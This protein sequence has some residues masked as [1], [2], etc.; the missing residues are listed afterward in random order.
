MGKGANLS[1]ERTGR[2]R[3][4]RPGAILLLTFG[5]LIVFAQPA[6]A[7]S[8][9]S[10]RDL[11]QSVGLSYAYHRSVGGS[12]TET[13]H[14]FTE[15]YGIGFSYSLLSPLLLKGNA[16]LDLEWL[17]RSD[18]TD[19]KTRSNSDFRLRY[20]I[21]GQLLSRMPYPVSIAATSGRES[22]AQS[23]APSYDVV[24]DD[25]RVRLGVLND[26]VPASV[27]FDRQSQD[28]SGLNQNFRQT[29]NS[30]SIAATPLLGKIATLSLGVTSSESTSTSLDSNVTSNFASIMGT[31]GS[32]SSWRSSRGL[33]RSL[34][35][36]YNYADNAG[37]TPL[38]NKNL[39]GNLYW[40]LGKALDGTLQYQNGSSRSSLFTTETQ[41]GAFSLTHRLF[42]SLTTGLNLSASE[43]RFNGGN[44]RSY[45][46]GVRV[47]YRK[48]LPESSN[49]N[50]SYSF[51]Q[52]LNERT[53]DVSA[54]AVL[55]EQH[56]IPATIPRRIPLAH[57]TFQA[58]GIQVVSAQT[59]LPYPASFFTIVPE[60]IELTNFFAGDT[61]VLVSYSYRQDPSVTTAST[62][63]GITAA[64]NLYQEKYRLYADAMITDQNL[65]QGEATQ[66][67]LTNT[68]HYDA[69]ATARLS[70][71]TL[72]AEAGY[73]KNYAQDLYYLNT[74]WRYGT[75]FGLG[76]LSV[77]AS[78]RYSWQ[79]LSQGSGQVSLWANSFNVQ[80]E[81]SRPIGLLAGRFKAD[82]AN[83][84]VEGGAMSHTAVVGVNIEGR[85]GRL[86][87][88]LTS[89]ATWTFS[90]KGTSSSQG[91]G[92]SIRRTF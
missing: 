49:L 36:A 1:Q 37:T 84:L 13:E 33:F 6:E 8:L 65:V 48:L 16:M 14:E 86:F 59:L 63:H 15:D 43:N 64:L 61:A 27:T 2:S 74:S 92:I 77:N 28:T 39:N 17:Q 25:L 79:S 53:G 22:V 32:Q 42:E 24:T 23:F 38:T 46:G 60:G 9:L 73:D 21:S 52:G 26:F 62:S 35:I 82:Y 72:S 20:N 44:T 12:S 31:A 85:F 80:S 19:D 3:P 11:Y 76:A 81:Y 83:V 87:A 91:V 5:S 47:G 58:A 51:N 57:P 66:L 7:L 78:D 56:P 45:N 67:T 68:R 70:R 29:A 89:N 41:S 71:H 88:L 50:L 34:S 40:Q 69:G 10:I 75:P 54:V 55:N 18:V 30:F 4:V 90:D